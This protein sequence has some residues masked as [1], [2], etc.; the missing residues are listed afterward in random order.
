MRAC[1]ADAAKREAELLR[2]RLPS[3]SEP[4]VG[5]AVTSGRPQLIAR[6]TEEVLRAMS[7]SDEDLV[8]LRSLGMKAGIVVRLS[9]RGRT[10]GALTL[11]SDEH[12]GRSYQPRDVRF[13]E[14][15]A[16]RV[17]LALDNA[18]LFTELQTMESQL[19]A[20]LGNLAEAVTVQNAQGSLIYANQAAADVLGFAS[21]QEL[22]ATPTTDVVERYRSF[23]EDGSP[24]Q[25]SDLPGRRV[26]D[27]RGSRATDPSGCRQAHGRAALARDEVLGCA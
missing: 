24:L 7:H 27:G 2:R 12:S 1:G 6:F 16:G 21:P 5:A 25:L 19:T 17:A 22:L 15:L 10:L 11:L 3:G 23:R 4:G 14:V 13:V 18:G 8:M 20:A 9:G 26:S